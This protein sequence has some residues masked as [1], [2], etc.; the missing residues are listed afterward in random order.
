MFLLAYQMQ[1]SLA[2]SLPFEDRGMKRSRFEVLR[3]ARMPAILVEGGFMSNP[4]DAAKIYDAAFRKKMARAVVDGIPRLQ[5][6]RRKAPG[7]EVDYLDGLLGALPP[8][9]PPPA[10]R[11]APTMKPIPKNP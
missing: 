5:T 6:L 2:R 7:Q 9:F 11:M 10:M 4:G 3:E 1:K 8:F